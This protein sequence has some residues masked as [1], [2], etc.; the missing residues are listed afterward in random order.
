MSVPHQAT[1]NPKRVAL[2]AS[3]GATIEW[4]DFF[5]YGT[6]AGLVFDK[7]YFNGL[8][9]TAATFASFGTFAVGFLARPIG[10]LIF[11]HFGD[12]IGRKTMLIWTLMIMGVGTS[13]VGLLPTYDSIGVLAP[14][15]LVVLRI[16]QGIGVGG[17]YGGAVLLA[18]E[19]APRGRRG[20]YGSFAHIGV[21]GGL[22]LASGAFAIASQ[23]PDA[24]FLAWGW[25]V[26][27]LISIVLLGIGAWIRLSIME[28]PSFQEVQAEKKVS[29]LPVAELFRR[30]PRTLLLGMGTRFVE[31]FTYNLYSVFLLSYAVTDAGL[32]RSVV[33]DAI[34]AGALLGVIMTVVAGALSDRFGRRPVYTVGAVTALVI[35][36]PVA[37]AVQSGAVV[38]SV[39]AFV[40]GLGLVY[41][42]VYGPLAAFWSEL[43]DTR[44]RFSALNAL[45][46]ISGV[47]ASGLTPLIA[48]ALVA[49]SDDRSLWW[50]A[51]Y[52]VVVAA[53]SLTCMWLL[54]ETRGEELRDTAVD[55][56]RA[57]PAREVVAS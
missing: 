27:F 29:K 16:L 9:G 25:R 23:L 18:T 44:Y 48:A 56:A 14:I 38:A 54:P 52:N 8:S 32:S 53:I 30:Q 46:Q 37:A 55:D 57:E 17:E 3:V 43:F 42:T 10:G 12:R 40:G 1:A 28:T 35:A 19:Y 34:M 26:C 31:G 36:F 51:G 50:V 49:L 2:A 20:L 39:A 5:L 45:Y 11:G 22:V 24:A 4:Y 33:L 6:A 7:L 13:L 41:G 21:P 15:A 47:V